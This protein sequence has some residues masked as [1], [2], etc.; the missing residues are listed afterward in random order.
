MSNFYVYG[1]TMVLVWFGLSF[2]LWRKLREEYH[3]EEILTFTL[4]ITLAVVTGLG[5]SGVIETGKLGG[6]SGWGMVLGLLYAV[7]KWSE[8]RNWDVWEIADLLGIYGMRAWVIIS[9]VRFVLGW[10]MWELV[11][12]LGGWA[13]VELVS[14]GYRKF[15]WY[16][17]GKAGLAGLTALLVYCVYE[18]VVAF[19]TNAPVYWWGLTGG[20]TVAGWLAG[21]TLITIYVRGGQKLFGSVKMYRRKR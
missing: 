15:F 9:A 7:R 2:S 17:S 10:G 21:F 16:P 18:I 19:L 12:A 5:L 1:F 13:T 3:N 6:V 20:Q 14:R 4:I 8:G 11:F